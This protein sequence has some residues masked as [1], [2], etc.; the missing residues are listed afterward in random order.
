[1]ENNGKQEA[2]IKRKSLLIQNY[3]NRQTSS[4]DIMTK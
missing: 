2:N 4:N 1:M 3:E